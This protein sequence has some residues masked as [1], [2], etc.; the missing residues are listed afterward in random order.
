[1]ALYVFLIRAMLSHVYGRINLIE[2]T[3]PQLHI[4]VILKQF[5]YICIKP[6]ESLGCLPRHVNRVARGPNPAV[7]AGSSYSTQNYILFVFF[8]VE[9]TVVFYFLLSAALIVCC[10]MRSTA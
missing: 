8:S 7:R 9:L 4:N 5:S 2:K 6:G 3:N 10:E 1:M